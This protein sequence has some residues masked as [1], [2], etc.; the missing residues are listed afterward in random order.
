MRNN[1]PTAWR[2]VTGLV[3][4]ALL[5]FAAAVAIAVGLALAFPD[6]PAIAVVADVICAL[7]LTF[8]LVRRS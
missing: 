7:A 4:I 5:G 8:F 3:L 6:R 1:L 2:V